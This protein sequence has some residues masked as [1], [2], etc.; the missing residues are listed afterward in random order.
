MENEETIKHLY[1]ELISLDMEPTTEYNKSLTEYI[2]L[3]EELDKSL[4][5]EE[6]K[7]V[8]ELEEIQRKMNTEECYQCFSEGFST[9]IKLITEAIYKK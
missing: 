7:K 1:S 3:R 5:E 2:D 8:D 9:G 4:N 6:K